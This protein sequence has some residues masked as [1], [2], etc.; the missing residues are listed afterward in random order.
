LG[1]AIAYK[2]NFDGF[3]CYRKKWEK[4]ECHE[5]EVGFHEKGFWV[6]WIECIGSI[7]LNVEKLT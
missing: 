5:A 4:E 1:D 7:C 2:G 3:L 6:N